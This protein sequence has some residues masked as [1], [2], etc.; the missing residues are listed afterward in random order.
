[1]VRAVLVFVAALI[2][3]IGAANAS[4]AGACAPPAGLFKRFEVGARGG[5]LPTV[6]F[7]ADGEREQNLVDF[8]GR[9]LVVNF[10]A[11]WCPPCV[12]EMPALERLRAA[13]ADDGIEVLAISADREGAAIVRQFYA[14]NAIT[15]LAVLIDRMGALGRALSVA[16]LPTTVLIDASGREVGRV[17]GIA[18]WDDPETIAFVRACLRP[19]R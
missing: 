1:M 16:G 17:L 14:R 11:T 15:G 5:P 13:V 3:G 4:T 6:P 10:W 8:R 7:F 9:G 12:K 18:E 19:G 2:V